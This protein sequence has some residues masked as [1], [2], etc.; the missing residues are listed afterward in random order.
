MLID[1][2]QF[3]CMKNDRPARIPAAR[4]DFGRLADDYSR[5]GK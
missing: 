1:V 5:D 4:A 3:F 2:G